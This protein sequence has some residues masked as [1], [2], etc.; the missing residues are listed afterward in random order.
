M[1]TRHAQTKHQLAVQKEPN[2]LCG[3]LLSLYEQCGH[4]MLIGVIICSEG[5]GVSV[6]LV[7]IEKLMQVEV[8]RL[9]GQIDD[10]ML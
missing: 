10:G 4:N 6:R 1:N 7:V 5:N 2:C 3:R 9:N 8:F